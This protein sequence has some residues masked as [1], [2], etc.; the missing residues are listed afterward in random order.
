MSVKMTLL[1]IDKQLNYPLVRLTNNRPLLFKVYYHTILPVRKWLYLLCGGWGRKII[2]NITLKD[3]LDSCYQK[4][5][6]KEDIAKYKND[7]LS[8][9]VLYGIDP[10]EYFLYNFQHKSHDER[11]FF[12]SDRERKYGCKNASSWETYDELRNKD[13]FYA[14]AS[15]FFNRDVC[16]VKSAEDLDKFKEFVQKQP[17]FF[18]K[19]IDGTF[20]NGAGIIDSADYS[21]LEEAFQPFISTPEKWMLE[22]IIQQDP[23]MGKWNPSSVNT[24][25]VH[26]F[27]TK[28]GKYAILNPTL[29]TGRKGSVV[30]NAGAGGV[31]AMIDVAT[32]KIATQGIDKKYNRYDCHPDSKVQFEGTQIPQWEELKKTAEA[33]HRS[34]PKHH[35]YVGFDFALSTKGWVLIEG[36][37][38][39]LIGSQTASQ[40]GVRYQFEELMGLPADTC[41]A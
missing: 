12:L 38:G 20:G 18:A 6:D 30:D 7:I 29:R 3:K 11:R 1:K 22:E 9:F 2:V 41:Y 14:L 36:N 37:W 26:S 10:E 32:G 40:K 8:A 39:Q 13:A 25:R 4:F 17:R 27:L 21:S 5:G 15:K 31:T 33:V 23:E 35:R 24:I 16:I 28:E 34:L 19:P